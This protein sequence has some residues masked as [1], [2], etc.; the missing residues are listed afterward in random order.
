MLAERNGQ[1]G[2][3]NEGQLASKD[4]DVLV[5]QSQGRGSIS[6]SEMPVTSEEYIMLNRESPRPRINSSITAD[7]VP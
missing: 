2:D 6:E 1:C 7:D 3:L 4:V 5:Q